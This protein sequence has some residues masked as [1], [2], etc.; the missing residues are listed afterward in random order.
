MEAALTFARRRRLGPFGPGAADRAA[1]DR[2]LAAMM[3]AGHG[4]ALSRRIVEA[5][6]PI[7]PDDL[8]DAR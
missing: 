4:F 7:E 2:Q 1:R 3:R 8:A 5:T 6:E